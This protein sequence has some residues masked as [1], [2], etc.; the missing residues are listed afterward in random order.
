D[1]HLEGR[2]PGFRKDDYPEVILGKLAWSLDYAEEH[3]LL[4]ALLGDVFDKPR[5]NPTWMIARLIDML[6]GRECIGIYG[7]HDCADP[8]L[9]DNDSLMLLFKSGS[10]RRVREEDPWRGVMG[11]RRVVIGG[12][13][14]RER[15]PQTLSDADAEDSVTAGV[16]AGAASRPFGIWLSHHDIIQPGYEEQGRIR[17]R[18]I[19]GVDLVVNG[20]IHRELGE[21]EVGATRWVTPGNISRRSRSDAVRDHVPSVLRLDVRGEGAGVGPEVPGYELTRVTVPHAPFDEVFHPLVAGEETD[22]SA[23]AFV[24]GLAELQA[25]RTQSGAGLMSFLDQN[26]DQ[27]DDAVAAEIRSLAEEVTGYGDG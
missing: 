1:P 17:P 18:E 5:D 22:T 13:S 16:A 6:A 15:L 25:R 8:E 10:V 20:H 7:N 3:R 23:S 14:Y 24:S 2:Q 12:A 9:N 26:L 4:P 27:F 19:P 21:V 11:G